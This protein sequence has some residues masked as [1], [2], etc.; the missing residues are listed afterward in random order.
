MTDLTLDE[1]AMAYI[2]IQHVLSGEWPFRRDEKG[3]LLPAQEM[4]RS[5]QI[6]RQT[7]EKL[8]GGER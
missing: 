7:A 5:R 2:C 3:R 8:W 4:S 6:A 1:R